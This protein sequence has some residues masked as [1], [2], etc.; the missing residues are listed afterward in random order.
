[1]MEEETFL[2]LSGIQHYIFCPRQWALIHIEKQWAENM[3]T[4]EGNIVHTRAHDN[5]LREHRGNSIIIRGLIVKSD[6][7]HLMGECDVVE[8]HKSSSGFPLS[9]E[10]GAWEVVPVEYKRGKSKIHDGDRAQLCAQAICL[11]EMFC[12]EIEYGFLYY[13]QTRSRE[14][15]E[16]DAS[17]RR[18]VKMATSEMFELYNRRHTPKASIKTSCKS[19]SLK[20]VCVPEIS[21]IESAEA[22][23]R[24]HLKD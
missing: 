4:A 12:C 2:A 9:G 7:L 8:F 15:V 24:R 20:Y 13:K 17:L 6:G 5:Q 14:K 19:C 10:E 22:Y 1:M 21:N 11:E 18:I 3:F 16:F 23:I